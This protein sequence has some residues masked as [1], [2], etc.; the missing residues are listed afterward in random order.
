MI[1]SFDIFDTLLL[2]PYMDPQ[3]VWR[4]L[5]EQEGAKGF[6][7]A[8][9]AADAKTYQLSSAENRETT[10]E[11]AYGLIP[12]WKHLMRKEMELERKVLCANPE[13]LEMWN[14]LGEEGKM[15]IIVSDMYL[16][17]DFIQSV[18]RD[19]GFDGWDAF[20]LSRDYN[21][22]KTTRKLFKI[23]LEEQN[24]RPSEIIHIGD[25]EW[26]DVKM[27]KSLGMNAMHYKKVSERF[28]DI[29]PF[30]RHINGR[31]AGTLAVGWHKFTFEHKDVTYWHRLGFLM[32]GV[33]G[34]IYV[35]W[36]VDT[37]KKLGKT[38][39]MFVA[40]DGYI[41][42]KICSELYPEM[43]TDYIYA[44]RMVS[45]AVLGAIG[46][47]PIAIQDR[48]RYIDEELQ[49]VNLC[50][51]RD[52][53]KAYISKYIFDEHTAIV[54]GCSSGFS[55]QRLIEGAMGHKVFAFYL[56][57]MAK[58][59][60]AAALYSTKGYS[61]PFQMLSEF[62][63]GSPEFP[64]RGTSSQGPIY[65]T[66][67]SEEER[68]KMNVS[69]EITEGAVECAKYLSKNLV[70]LSADDWISFSDTFMNN[71][72]VD[73]VSNL[74]NAKNAADVQQK[75]FVP[76]VWKPYGKFHLWGEKW[77]RATL[78]VYLII[79]KFKIRLYIGRGLRLKFINMA[80]S[81]NVITL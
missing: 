10:I 49:G 9:K 23:M 32:G 59:H 14:K 77:G 26:S 48:Q 57:S 36:I 11:E 64:I 4:V 31:L 67:I 71:L 75:L 63:F 24:A 5:E 6:A 52:D 12:Q 21:A 73:D 29:C 37:A 70:S 20:Y 41:W 50:K 53:Y 54:D 34:Y 79:N 16:P 7:K 51:I 17:A 66:A 13:T 69:E 55:A 81:K 18:L 72:T 58:M 46:S 56:L 74:A 45:V 61:M 30:A 28:Y 39:L 62:L 65:E 8:R 43:E 19:N 78:Y 27:P 60:N 35:S 80:Y 40:R 47:D 3:E 68:F 25:N 22:R 1:Y 44:P 42:Q 2:R 38:R 33:L 15:R 76:I